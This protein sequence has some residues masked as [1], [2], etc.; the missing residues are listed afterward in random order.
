MTSATKV[1][2]HLVGYEVGTCN[3]DWACPCQFND[4]KPTHGFC[5]A[6]STFLIEKGNYGDTRLDGALFSWV[7]N[8]PGPVHEGNGTRMLILDEQTTADQRAA[9]TALTSGTE[10]HPFFEIFTSVTPNV[11]DAVVAPIELTFDPEQ[12]TARLRIKGLA[13]NDVEPIK[14]SVGDPLRIRLDL[15]NGFEFKQ[16]EIANSTRWKV[17]GKAPLAMEHERTYTHF[18]RIDWSGDGTTR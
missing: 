11:H 1:D 10:G 3:C 15:P 6:I 2:W 13:E 7:F 12:R 4:V 18:A 9:I 14:G 17:T 16:A 8:W 5:E